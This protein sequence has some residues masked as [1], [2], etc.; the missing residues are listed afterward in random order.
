MSNKAPEVL[1]K[2]PWEEVVFGFELKSRLYPGETLTSI[3]SLTIAPSGEV[4]IIAQSIEE[5]RVIV[6]FSSG[7]A[8]AR[9]HVAGKVVTSLQRL[10]FCGDLRVE[11]C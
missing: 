9:Y 6:K 4:L 11:S 3:D 10:E 8:G 1:E 7:T 2:T 5:T